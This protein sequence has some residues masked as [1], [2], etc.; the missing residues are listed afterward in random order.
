MCACIIYI[1]QRLTEKLGPP[2]SDEHTLLFP[3]LD[4]EI[5][6]HDVKPT[7]NSQK[8]RWIRE[9]KQRIHLH[10]IMASIHI[11][12]ICIHD[13]RCTLF[14]PSECIHKGYSIL[15]ELSNWISLVTTPEATHQQVQSNQ[16]T[17]SKNGHFLVC[18]CWSI[19]ATQSRV[20]ASSSHNLMVGLGQLLEALP[21]SQAGITNPTNQPM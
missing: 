5:P 9:K 20:L 3:G 18:L 7:W 19:P 16:D 12:S 2:K 11:C 8:A 10:W 1:W 21:Q 17:V 15:Q 14:Q 13:Y 6:C 4:L